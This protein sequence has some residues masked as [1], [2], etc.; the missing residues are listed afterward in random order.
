MAKKPTYE[1]LEQRLKEIE[2]DA[3]NLRQAEAMLRESE[4]KYRTLVEDC[5]DGIA[6]VQGLEVKFVNQGLLKIFGYQIE[7]VVNRPF[8]DFISPEH[9]NLLKDRGFGREKG[10]DMPNYYEFKALRKDGTAFDADLSVGIIS[11][12]GSIARQ[13]IVRDITHRKQAEETLKKS[14]EKREELEKIINRSPGVVFLWRAAEG[15]P[16][17]FVSENVRE[18][19]YRPE[20]F[21]SGKVSYADIVYPEDL[22]R[23]A[24]EVSNYSNQEGRKRFAQEYRIVT[25]SGD[26]RWIDDRTWIRRNEDGKVTHFQGIGIDITERKQAEEEKKRLEGQLLQA[27]KM[28]AIGTLAGGIAHDFNNLLMGIQGRVSLMSL[29]TDDKHPHVEHFKGIE[30]MVRRG[31][32]LTG[33]LLGFA[34]GGKYQVKPT[35]LSDIVLKSSQ[36]F[37]RTKK[38]IKISCLYQ[39]DLWT[40]E[41]DQEQIEQV[42]LNLYVNSGQAMPGG[43]ALSLQTEN[44]TLEESF[45]EVFQVKPGKY[46]KVIVTDTGGGM[47]EET[48]ARIFDPF[49]TTK[50]MG[51]GTGL[52]LASAYGVIKS[53]GGAIDVYSKK[54]EG[55]T[56]TIYLPASE[57][58]IVKKKKALTEVV[59]GE[60]TVLLVDDEDMIIE[61]G[62]KVLR[63][64]GYT[65]LVARSGKE[66]IAKYQERQDGI[67]MVI[68]D[69]IMPDIG[70]GDTF[71]RLKEI[72]PDIK[73]LLASGYSIDGRASEILERG[74]DGFI[75][76]PF[77]MQQLSDKIR[78]ILDKEG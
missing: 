55:T 52:S 12:E 28:K 44:V 50:E 27:Q 56:I 70:G 68:L 13:G 25:S 51:R 67:D 71:D 5:A 8:T 77:N 61:V 16:V 72:N 40:V 54:G 48:K 58:R 73:V 3:L 62:S 2:V 18:F 17:E 76:K 6:I 10:E 37:G 63:A 64:L 21:Y 41:V 11:Y 22:E 47:D 69:M 31:A 33:Q 30:D 43:G 36:M 26:V 32:D 49:F 66:A 59:K 23:V 78:E 46:V 75:Q 29:D 14:L 15:W 35:D 1:E 42:L 60:E 45:A 24:T 20:E 39:K 7:E 65:V 34:R 53:H 9:R 19:G 57:K 74:C 38:E 4:S